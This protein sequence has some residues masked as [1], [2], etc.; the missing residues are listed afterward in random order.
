[1][2]C[3]ALIMG[4]GAHLTRWAFIFV[5]LWWADGP[6]PPT[7]ARPGQG[8]AGGNLLWQGFRE[9]KGVALD[10]KGRTRVIRYLL[11]FFVMS[12]AIQ[13]IMLMASS[14]GIKEIQL[15]EDQLI[16][17]IIVVQIVAIP[18]SFL[19]SRLSG[20]YG[21]VPVL[22]VA[23]FLWGA[24]CAF[25]YSLVNGSTMFFI[26]AG[27]IG[28]MMG[29]TQS[30]N[31]STYTKMCRRPTTPRPTSA[32]MRCSKSSAWSSACSAGATSRA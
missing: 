4:V 25:A 15:P 17:A 14:F 6:A 19:F 23:T 32:S 16:V 30:L 31:R 8:P 3:L 27:L 7:H 5:G 13:T 2:L 22:I 28:F 10:L 29:G 18:G 9:L 26:A 24:T 21:N 11:S 1:M 20:R 12:M